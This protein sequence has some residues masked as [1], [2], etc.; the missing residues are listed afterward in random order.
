VALGHFSAGQPDP[1]GSIQPARPFGQAG[2]ERLAQEK[3]FSTRGDRPESHSASLITLVQ[4]HAP[5]VGWP[6]LAVPVEHPDKLF[7]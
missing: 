3:A 4:Y 6:L 1:N 7:A 2:E 5:G